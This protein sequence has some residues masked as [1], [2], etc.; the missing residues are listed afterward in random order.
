MELPEFLTMWPFNAIKLTGHRIGL[1]DVVDAYQQ[2]ENAEQIHEHYPSLPL[3]L[4]QK[5][6]DFYH[7]N[8]TEVDA[9]VAAWQEESARIEASLPRVDLEQLRRR[10][11]ERK[12]AGGS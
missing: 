1:Y 3:E 11:E 9:Y 5:V 10:L 4:I 2:G 7:A 8:Q 12:R 6:L